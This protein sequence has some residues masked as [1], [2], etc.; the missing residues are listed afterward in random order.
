M[1]KQ[2]KIKEIR[3][4]AQRF[5]PDEIE[6]CIAQQLQEGKNVCEVA[7]PADQVIDELAKAEFVRNLVERG[8]PLLD[9][10]RELARRI[11]QVQKGHGEDR[12]QE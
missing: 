7:G 4:L 8:T 3:E 11:R 5:T 6:G 10:I 2:I 12:E 1:Q 9:A